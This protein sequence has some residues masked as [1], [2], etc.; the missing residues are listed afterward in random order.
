V[1]FAFQRLKIVVEPSGAAGLAAVMFG[2]IDVKGKKVGVTISGGN[3]DPE[4]FAECI[5]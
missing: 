4:T 5:R 1:K 3:V 2:K